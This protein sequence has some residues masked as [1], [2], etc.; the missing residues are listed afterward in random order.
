MT[1]T[2]VQT[3]SGHGI[4]RLSN[5]VLRITPTPAAA[6]MPISAQNIQ[7]GKKAP[8]NSYEGAPAREQPMSMQL[9]TASN[10]TLGAVRRAI[11]SPSAIF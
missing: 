4:T 8:N 6:K 9:G 2:D 7:A 1:P 10:I 3:A 11:G 5:A